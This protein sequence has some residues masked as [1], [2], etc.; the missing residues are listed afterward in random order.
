[1]RRKPSRW[2][3]APLALLL[4]TGCW[5]RREI[6]ERTST[7]M[8]GVDLCT[9]QEDCF[10]VSTRQFAIPGR[11]PLG[12]GGRGPINS[13]YVL[14]SPGKNAP[15]SMRTAQAEAHRD[16]SF[17]HQRLL[18]WGEAF[19]RRGL[20]NYLDYL[21]RIPEVR[22]LMWVGV[23]EGHAGEM[24]HA[25][26]ELEAVPAL[27][28]NDL[29]DEAVK[30]G[31]LPAAITLGDFMIKL[32]GEGEEPFAPLFRM[33]DQDHAEIA[34]LAVFRDARLVGKLSFDELGTFMMIQG[35]RRSSER[36]RI[37]LPGGRHVW[38]HVY[39]RNVRRQIRWEERRVH[40]KLKVMLETELAA[41][42]PSVVGSDAATLALIEEQA[43]REIRR[44]ALAL[45]EK[46][47]QELRSD[48]LGLGAEVRAYLPAAWR[49]IPD[50]PA[51]F[52]QAK[53]DCDIT[54]AVRRTGPV[55][56]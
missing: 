56:N 18:V 12:A 9:E 15:D 26:P 44:R 38:L 22:R 33:T 47:Q 52:S 30:T 31:R 42:S 29:V 5:D 16:I 2:W 55:M 4:L 34:G 53:I 28:F 1:M 11:I 41:A 37:E 48:I 10:L 14:Q 46:L 35:R 6:E 23:V 24:V 40:L 45:V 50:W 25:R 20:Q 43:G 49:Q 36:V 7:L 19:A 39:G 3:A 21:W 54:V 13:V 51:A 27:Y 17:A 8:T 32:S